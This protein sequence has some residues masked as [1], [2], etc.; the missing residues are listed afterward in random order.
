[1]GLPVYATRRGVLMRFSFLTDSHLSASV[2]RRKG[3]Y[4][5]DIL[6]KWE[7]IAE[8]SSKNGC[9]AVVFGGDLYDK[10]IVPRSI[11]QEVSRLL[12]NSPLPT[13]ICVGQH[14]TGI[15]IPTTEG[16]SIDFLVSH[17]NL[18]SSPTV[19]ARRDGNIILWPNSDLPVWAGGTKE[20]PVGGHGVAA[21]VHAYLTPTPLPFDHILISDITLPTP[22]ICLSGDLHTGFPITEHNGTLFANPGAISRTFRS[23]DDHTRWPQFA[24][25]DTESKNMIEYVRLPESVVRPASEIYDA[26]TKIAE[27]KRHA[28]K[29]SVSEAV[30]EIRKSHV[31]TWNSTL[32]RALED[33]A[34]DDT[35]REGISTLRSCCEEYERTRSK[36][37]KDE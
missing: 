16:K 6:V 5:E 34:D 15:G 3:N 17:R 24:V 9:E 14:D 28:L 27:E 1:M 35:R 4:V 36:E 11:E 2:G 18:T 30:S 19:T 12:D 7:W 22:R 33:S 21:V 26:E 23:A 10:S 13:M 37:D 32:E 20:D 29:V 31:E 8:W 25:V